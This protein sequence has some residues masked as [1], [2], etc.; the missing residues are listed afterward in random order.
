MHR[1]QRPWWFVRALPLVR[2][3]Q[4]RLT[5]ARYVICPVSNRV[6]AP[7]TQAEREKCCG[8]LSFLYRLQKDLNPSPRTQVQEVQERLSCDER[9]KKKPL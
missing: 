2:E 4:D 8:L 7:H 1:N 9:E 3:S 6:I 5:A